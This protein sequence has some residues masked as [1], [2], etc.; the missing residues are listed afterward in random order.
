MKKTVLHNKYSQYLSSL[1]FISNVEVIVKNDVKFDLLIG[2]EL[3]SIILMILDDYR[4]P[5]VYLCNPKEGA[6]RKPHQLY[7][8]K[9]GLIHLCLSVREDISVKIKGYKNILD[10]TLKRIIRL[11]SLNEQEEQ[12][13]FRKE[14]LYFWNQVSTN[15]NKVKLF[16]SSSLAAKKLKMFIKKETI[17]AID[18]ELRLND[19]FLGKYSCYNTEG[20]YI[21]LIN[22]SSILPPFKEEPW[23]LDTLNSIM[24]NCISEKNIEFLEG[25]NITT[26]NVVLAF[27]MRISEVIPITFLLKVEFSNSKSENI[28]KRLNRVISTEHWSSQR[29]DSN[30]LFERIGVDTEI[31]N[32]K[33][34]VVGAGSLGSYILSEM[35]KIGVNNITIYDNDKLSDDNIMRH[36]LGMFY[37]DSNKAFAMKFELESNYPQVLVDYKDECFIA[38]KIDSYELEQYSLIIIATGGTDFML[39]INK[40]F[41]EKSITI[42]VIFTW[43]EAKGIGV[44]ALRVDYR[45]KGC[46]QCLYTGNE[47]NKAHYSNNQ[48]DISFV[49][50]GCGGVFNSY[51]N[52]TLLKGCAMILEVI[53]LQL[54]GLLETE[55]NPLYSVRTSSPLSSDYIIAKRDFETSREFYISERCEICGTQ[56]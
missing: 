55:T 37:G 52:I 44:H 22:S 35:P 12:K 16:I 39:N 56:I 3:Y 8:R 24:S 29:C 18:D 48:S 7:S 25:L 32:K 17:A 54:Q 47:S 41:K 33:V 49:G 43:I 15:T 11:L 1:G 21:P 28:F 31:L 27:E 38:N 51:G 2:A 4:L 23:G 42:P 20:I 13:E 14:F 6:A 19:Y 34:L 9:S 45:K 30:Y 40:M 53:Q 36:R 50:T 5:I 26:K 10:Y 46:F